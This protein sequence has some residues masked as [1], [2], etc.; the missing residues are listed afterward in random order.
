[1]SKRMLK[2]RAYVR[3]A[4]LSLNK[5]VSAVLDA[6]DFGIIFGD[7]SGDS[8]VKEYAIMRRVAPC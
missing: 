8:E 1:M 7:G 4:V 5:I 2:C 6:E 3:L